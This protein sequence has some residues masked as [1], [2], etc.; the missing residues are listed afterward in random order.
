MKLQEAAKEFKGWSLYR[1]GKEMSDIVGL[2]AIYS[3]ASGR[4]SPNDKYIKLICEKL[5]CDWSI[6]L[7]FYKQGEI[8]A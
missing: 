5:G 7:G 3:W 4:T 6:N 8:N 2:Q 1:L